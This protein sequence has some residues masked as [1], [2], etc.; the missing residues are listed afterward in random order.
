M[1]M[2]VLVDNQDWFWPTIFKEIETNSVQL[3]NLAD[4][5][6]P[7]PSQHSSSVKKKIFFFLRLL[8]L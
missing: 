5:L 2:T 1:E 8:L 3:A 7:N 4:S 6:D